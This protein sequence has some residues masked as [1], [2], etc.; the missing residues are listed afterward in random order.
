[1]QLHIRTSSRTELLVRNNSAK[2]NETENMNLFL[3]GPCLCVNLIVC[4]V[5]S[6]F[7]LGR[8]LNQVYYFI[9]VKVFKV[10]YCYF[11]F[12]Q[13]FREK[14]PSYGM[15]QVNMYL[16]GKNTCYCCPVVN[17]DKTAGTDRKPLLPFMKVLKHPRF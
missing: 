1:M 9:A 10:M 14:L 12:P 6:W 8:R 5:I 3:V 7:S 11:L 16:I 13:R 2:S 4:H 17:Q 15:R